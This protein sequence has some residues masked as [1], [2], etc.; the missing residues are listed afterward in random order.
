MSYLR[1]TVLNNK[2]NLLVGFVALFGFQIFSLS[3]FKSHNAIDSENFNHWIKANYA[4]GT[5]ALDN[6]L[7]SPFQGLGGLIQP[8][9]VR[10][11]LPFI[12]A[13]LLS[14]ADPHGVISI[15]SSIF[16]GFAIFLLCLSLGLGATQSLIT[17]Q[18]GSIFFFPPIWNLLVARSHFM[19]TYLFSFL[20]AF[21]FPVALGTFFLSVFLQLGKKSAK[22]NLVILFGMLAT[23]LY[24][25]VSDPLYTA[26]F[27]LPV[28]FFCFGIFCASES[29]NIMFWRLGGGFFLILACFGLRVWTFYYGLFKNCA[30]AVFPNE[31]YVEV[32]QWD[33]YTGMFS[34]GGWSTPIFAL[35]SLACLYLVIKK[36][37]SLRGLAYAVLAYQT[38]MV[39]VSLIY[40][41]SGFRWNLPLPVYLEVGA[42]PIYLGLLSATIQDGFQYFSGK[43]KSLK[44]PNKIQA[45]LL[46]IVLPLIALVAYKLSDLA[47]NHQPQQRNNLALKDQDGLVSNILIPAVSIMSDGR[48]RGSVATVACVPGGG[49]LR[50]AGVSKEAPFTKEHIIV[51]CQYL[52]T[53]DPMLYMT[54]LWEQNIPTLEDNTHIVTPPFYYLISRCLRRAQDY[55]SRN[56]TIPT[57]IKPDLMAALGVKIIVTDQILSDQRAKLIFKQS[58]IDDNTLYIYE[59]ENPN[60]GN[61]SPTKLIFLDSAKNIVDQ[62]G[63]EG[64]PFKRQAIISKKE[65]FPDLVTASAGEIFYEQGGVR[66]RGK[67][68]GWS[69]LVL[70]LQFSNALKISESLHNN[71]SVKILRVNLVLTGVLFREQVHIKLVHQHGLVCGTSGRIQDIRDWQKLGIKEDGVVPYP[72]GYQPK[73]IKIK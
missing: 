48:F 27:W 42:V 31:L 46:L 59:L 55:Q 68:N 16:L 39:L 23:F 26:V 63:V 64:F 50:K 45:Q 51:L 18:L 13:Q 69:L 20:P 2:L 3:F 21:A 19:I 61:Y 28:G 17:G 32:Q 40:V 6:S 15:S 30:R 56:W 47:K 71:F 36:K 5:S 8:L 7:I 73:A 72:L 25:T 67:S 1:E 38:L 24:S 4:Y 57:I 41:Y 62:L 49:I 35:V 70:P 37:G 14:P 66:V 11:H 29:K 33:A 54:G 44:E 22:K 34:H 52:R 43:W 60:L 53:F 58:N 65:N 9:A 10:L 12:V